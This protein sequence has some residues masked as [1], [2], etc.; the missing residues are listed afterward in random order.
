MNANWI[1]LGDETRTTNK[2]SHDIHRT[3]HNV[4]MADLERAINVAQDRDF[5]VM[6][7]PLLRMENW[8][9]PHQPN[10]VDAF[11]REYEKWI[12][13]YAKIA[14]RAGAEMFS[15]GNEQVG[16]VVPG[17]AKR[18]AKIVNAV[19][20]V[21]DGQI[22][23]AAQYLNVDDAE[24]IWKLPAVDVISV[25]AYYPVAPK[26]YNGA[27]Y[28]QMKA[29]WTSSDH[30]NGDNPI[31]SMKNLFG[32]TSIIDYFGELA[33]RLG[34]P[35]MHS[36]FGYSALDGTAWHPAGHEGVKGPLDY[37]EQANAFRAYFDAWSDYTLPS[38]D[39]NQRITK[40]SF[41][42][43]TQLWWTIPPGSGDPR[44]HNY[45]GTPSENV[46]RNYFSQGVT[47]DGGTNGVG[48]DPSSPPVD[49]GGDDTVVVD[50]RG[51]QAGGQFAE[52]QLLIDGSIHAMRTVDATLR[53]YTFIVP[54]LDTAS[55]LEIRFPN[56]GRDANGND[57]NLFIEKVVVAGQELKISDATYERDGKTDLTG[58]SEL[59]WQG[60]LNFD[61]G[62]GSKPPTP[63]S[64]V[65]G[66]FGK[67]TVDHTGKWVA[68]DHS[69]ENPVVI[70]LT[71]SFNGA[72]EVSVRFESTGS[73]GFRAVLD[74]P[75]NRGSGH[76]K[77]TV[78]YLVIE[79]G[80][81]K[82]PDGT[83][84]QAGT[85][86][87]YKV[88]KDGAERIAFDKVFDDSPVV[89]TQLQSFN[90][91]DFAHA[92]KTSVDR[93]GFGVVIEE[94]ERLLNSGH[95][96]EKIGW[97][98][99]EEGSGTWSGHRYFADINTKGTTHDNTWLGFGS[100]FTQTPNIYAQTHSYKGADP[101]S[102]R[103]VNVTKNAVNVFLQEDQT[104]DAETGHTAEDMD[105]LALQGSGDLSAALWV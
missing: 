105:L 3:D 45:E 60:E 9:P 91:G 15:I 66:E 39:P 93:T 5:K 61:L 20:A 92:R 14:Q 4:P 80:T 65:I 29:A 76:T 84:L 51:T 103:Y 24:I 64:Q 17:N 8:Q 38:D 10:N 21:Y 50:A 27:T 95:G 46:I 55:T 42:L 75:S 67:L 72:D 48:D 81:W 89:L 32:T 78:S 18:W 37:Q 70:A 26:Y 90:G 19:D 34:K 35:V 85:E 63:S 33:E 30:F 16:T 96:N 25:N 41:F 104:K 2:Y 1:T 73:K 102:T 56:N 7:K 100:A 58:Q 99:I 36:E 28:S 101:A 97:V 52:M 47:D 31:W 88:P 94:E 98:A 71:P 54:D 12:V 43:G 74:E 77:E 87:T 57:R 6:V 83:K 59:W 82:L 86:T 69:Y 22:T 79:E 44:L 49:T 11:F 62:G 53:T 23:Y 40:D 13:D 68:F